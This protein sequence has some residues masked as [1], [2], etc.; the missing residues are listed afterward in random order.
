MNV[1]G[2]EVGLLLYE[3]LH[4][5]YAG[6]VLHHLHLHALPRHHALREGA[7]VDVLA[8][9]DSPDLVEE[10]GAGAHDAGGEGRHQGQTLPGTLSKLKTIQMVFFLQNMLRV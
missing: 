9:D 3:G 8:H 7:E 4:H 2:P 1:L 5:L 6:R 10:G